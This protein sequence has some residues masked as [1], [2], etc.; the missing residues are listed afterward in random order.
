MTTFAT[1]TDVAAHGEYT[2]NRPADD[3]RPLYRFS[4]RISRDG[5]TPFGSEAGRYHLYS[6]WFCPWAQRSVLVVELAGLTDAVSVSYVDNSRDARGWAFRA[7]NGPDPVNGFTLLREAYE[8]TQPGFDG[9]VSVPTLWDTRTGTIVSNDFGLLDIDLASQFDR[10]GIELYPD[11]LADQIDEL[12]G[13]I[14][15]EVNR[16]SGDVL[17]EALARLD[18]LLGRRAF[19][20]GDRLTLADVRLWVTLVRHDAAAARAGG[21]RLAE[22]PALWNYARALYALPAFTRTTDYDSFGGA[23]VKADWEAS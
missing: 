14:L 18:E 12:D 11:D 21:A 15:P 10:H 20:L 9:H 3:P 6:G 1:P 23:A 16:G 5:S 17:R 8:R 22:H 7:V 19:L 13:W 4:G 2:I